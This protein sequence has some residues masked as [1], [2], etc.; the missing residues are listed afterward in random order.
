MKQYKLL[1][2]N[3]EISLYPFTFKSKGSFY[4]NP[5]TDNLYETIKQ[6]DCHLC[7]GSYLNDL[8]QAAIKNPAFF[9]PNVWPSSTIPELEKTFKDMGLL[10]HRVGLML[11]RVCD[12]YVASQVII[13]VGTYEFDIC[14]FLRL[15]VKILVS[16]I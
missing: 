16:R 5:L 9:S 3:S 7:D 8:E 13:V 11:A 6:R 10:I 4:A 12:S 2:K 15:T 14:M 1:V